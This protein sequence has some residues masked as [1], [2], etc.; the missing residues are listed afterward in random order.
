[1][2]GKGET[3]RADSDGVGEVLDDLAHDVAAVGGQ[4]NEHFAAVGVVGAAGDEVTSFEAVEQLGD[5]GGGDLQ[6]PGDLG[7]GAGPV[8]SE[9]AEGDQLSGADAE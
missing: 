4:L 8:D 9:P 3:G 2:L 7:G 5:R 6:P 1:V